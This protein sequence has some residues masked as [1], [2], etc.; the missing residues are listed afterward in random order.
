MT[1]LD[2]QVNETINPCTMEDSRLVSPDILSTRQVRRGIESFSPSLFSHSRRQKEKKIEK[3]SIF[4]SDGSHA[5]VVRS[6]RHPRPEC[7]TRV[8]GRSGIRREAKKEERRL[9][10][11]PEGPRSRRPSNES[12][13]PAHPRRQVTVAPYRASS[14]SRSAPPTPHR[15]APRA[16]REQRGPS[17]RRFFSRHDP[18]P[19]LRERKRKM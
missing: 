10:G 9:P 15:P 6:S 8:R 12:T 3:R 7:P 2:L 14:P 16:A 17:C 4:L 19:V 13:R 5:T 18:S 11:A 1:A